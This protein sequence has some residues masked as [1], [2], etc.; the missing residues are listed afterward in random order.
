MASLRIFLVLLLAAPGMSAAQVLTPREFFGYALGDAFTPH[1]R[2]V[3]YFEHV[4]ANSPQV[5]LT[6]YGTTYEGRT[7]LYAVISSQ[8]NA[9]KLDTIRLGN[10]QRAGLAGG[11]PTEAAPAIVWLSY[12]VHGNESVSTEAAMAT[13]H[14]LTDPGNAKAQAWLRDVVVI[15]DPCVNPDGRDRYVSFFQRTRGRFPNYLPEAREHSEPW[16]GGRTNH[17]YF[18]LNRDWAWGTQTE[19]RQRLPEYQKWMPHIH[20]D[21][22]EQ[23]VNEPYYFAPAAEPYHRAV[24]PWQRELQELIGRNHAARFDERG[25][26][27][28][29]RQV[30]DL[31]YP[32]YGD[33]WP[34]FNGAVGMTYEQGGSGRAGLGI[35]TAEGDTL[36]LRDR[37]EHHYITSLST[38][39]AAALH[40]ERIVEEFAAF[41]GGV[42]AGPYATYVI[43]GQSPGRTAALARHLSMQGIEHGQVHDQP[44][45]EGY[46]YATGETVRFTINTHDIVISTQQPRHVLARVLLEPSAVLDDSLSYDIT[47]WSLP[48]VYNAEAYALAEE[49]QPDQAWSLPVVP[50]TPENAA[51]YLLDWCTFADAQLLAKLL[52]RGFNVRFTEAPIRVSNYSFSRGTMIITRGSNKHF[53]AA[54]DQEIKDTWQADPQNKLIPVHSTYVTQGVDFGSSDV[55]FLKAPGVAIVGG[56]GSSVYGLGELWHFFDQQLGY[57]ATLVDTGDFGRIHLYD[58]DVII[59]PSGSYGRILSSTVLDRLK[60]WVEDGGRLI[61]LEAAA[62]FLAGKDGFSLK[63]KEK[64]DDE[65]EEEPERRLYAD[66]G[67]DEVSGRV[68]GA[69]FR[70]DLDVTHPLAFGYGGP[71]YTLKRSNDAY[72]LLKEGWN[73]GVLEEDAHVSGFVGAKAR[74]PMENTLVFGVQPMGQGEVVYLLDNPLFRGFWYGGRMLMSNAVFLVGQRS[75][76]VY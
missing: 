42:P 18:D 52:Q 35:I 11:E 43:R 7:L 56:E 53:G 9:A 22:H 54:F 24:T 14:A 17:Y 40:Q 63:A 51:A 55:P 32:G 3:D 62:R 71:Y 41:F 10:L 70:V 67:R 13:V 76:S 38:I 8:Q 1:H 64:S 58:F 15:I 39:E 46:S 23:G 31:F 5:S 4:A 57:P 2:V 61:A 66:R 50:D 20:V 69:V 34:T 16:P 6:R 65:E 73:V 68:T 19:T 47:A 30:F 75:L 59:L 25:W 44:Q 49:V 60:Q 12:N 37:I 45:V 48:Y 72:E 21:F 36:T 26:L 33:T 74:Q 29:T 27:Y 28:F